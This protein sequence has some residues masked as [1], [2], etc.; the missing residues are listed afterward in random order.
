M[1]YLRTVVFHVEATAAGVGAHVVRTAGVRTVVGDAAGEG[2]A[3]AAIQ[4]ATAQ[5]EVV[6]STYARTQLIYDNVV[7]AVG[8][9]PKDDA[10]V[11]GLVVREGR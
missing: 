10:L 7:G 4:V 5:F 6:A 9:V 3:V 2:D 11:V 8:R 1:D